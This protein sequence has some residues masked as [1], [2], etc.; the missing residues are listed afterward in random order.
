MDEYK[1]EVK[2]Y[3]ELT[4][5]MIPSSNISV[6]DASAG[7]TDAVGT[8][9]SP[10][11]SPTIRPME[12]SS[13]T[14]PPMMPHLHQ[15][16]Q[17][18]TTESAELIVS[19]KDFAAPVSSS[20]EDEIDYSICSVS[21]NGHYIPSPGPAMSSNRSN[22]IH[23]DGTICDPLFEL[24]NEYSFQQSVEKRCVSPVEVNVDNVDIVDDGGF[25]RLMP[26]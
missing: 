5:N 11:G 13:S 20:S 9:V 26:C 17:Y 16:I 18:M 14:L 19:K 15:S 3:K 10:V 4:E 24:E 7:A 23:S 21:N 1:L 6:A 12:V 25:F 22:M 2:Q 8:M